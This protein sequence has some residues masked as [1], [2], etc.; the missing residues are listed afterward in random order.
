[1]GTLTFVT[2]RVIALTGLA[3]LALHDISFAVLDIMELAPCGEGEESR[4]MV[5][6]L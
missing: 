2:L 5:S 4:V 1:M 3:L 6:L